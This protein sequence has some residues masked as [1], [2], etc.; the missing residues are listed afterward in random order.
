MT[1]D[2]EWEE[3]FHRRANLN[4]QMLIKR[5]SNSVVVWE[6]NIKVTVR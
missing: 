4:D 3:A 1:K 5:C 2:N 6:M